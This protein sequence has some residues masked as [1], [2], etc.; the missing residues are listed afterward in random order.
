MDKLGA[1]LLFFFLAIFLSIAG[2]VAA[3]IR[4]RRRHTPHP[5]RLSL[6]G[7]YL[8]LGIAIGTAALMLPRRLNEI[9][10][11]VAAGL[12]Y[13]AIPTAVIGVVIGLIGARAGRCKPGSSCRS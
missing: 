7:A 9:P 5:V 2:A 1:L 11:I 8:G 3:A 12:M 6:A 4:G 13:F 10:N